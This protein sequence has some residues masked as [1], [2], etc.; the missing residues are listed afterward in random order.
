MKR[1]E[2]KRICVKKAVNKNDGFFYFAKW[3]E[4]E[5]RGLASVREKGLISDTPY[6]IPWVQGRT[7][8]RF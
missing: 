1:L 6:T 4:S 8:G 2:T 7:P 5:L 3:G